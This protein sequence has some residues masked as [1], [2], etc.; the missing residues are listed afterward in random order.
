M[1]AN[2]AEFINAQ[3]STIGRAARTP[4]AINEYWPSI[5]YWEFGH[6]NYRCNPPDDN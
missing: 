3:W 4:R 2:V 6:W 1:V 5:N